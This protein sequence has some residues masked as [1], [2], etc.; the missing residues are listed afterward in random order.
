MQFCDTADYKS[1]L[2]EP[3]WRR[4]LTWFVNQSGKQ[5]RAKV[6]WHF[7]SSLL[8]CLKIQADFPLFSFLAVV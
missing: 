3:N 5:G 8:C 2:L 6:S 4:R 1:A 7:V